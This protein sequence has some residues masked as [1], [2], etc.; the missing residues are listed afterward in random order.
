MTAAR[1][2]A[3]LG[4]RKVLGQGGEE[5]RRSGRPCHPAFPKRY[6]TARKAHEIGIRMALGAK[7]TDVLRRVVGTGLR[8]VV[9]GLAI[10]ITISL[11]LGGVI[12]TEQVGVRAYDPGTLAATTFL[13]ALT[14]AIAAWIPA[15]KA[16]RVDPVVALRYQ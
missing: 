12:R 13:L 9:L 14:A 2:A 3:V 10:G 11:T 15:R 7:G 8:L 5:T 16:A 6:A 1:I 4:G